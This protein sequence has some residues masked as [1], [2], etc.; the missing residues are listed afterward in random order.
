MKS[1]K[2]LEN[3]NHFDILM[4]EIYFKHLETTSSSNTHDQ[5]SQYNPPINSFLP[6]GRSEYDDPGNIAWHVWHQTP[7]VPKKV[8]NS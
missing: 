7:E 1:L 5:L 8:I 4:L 3:H 2:A 6:T